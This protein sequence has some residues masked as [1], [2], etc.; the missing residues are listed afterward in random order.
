MSDF[1]SFLQQSSLDLSSSERVHMFVRD[2][3]Y[4]FHQQQA[5]E[6]CSLF[7]STDKASAVKRDG[8]LESL[9]VGKILAGRITAALLQSNKRVVLWRKAGSTSSGSWVADKEASPGNHG[10]L[11]DELGQYL[12][13]SLD[14]SSSVIAAVHANKS[15]GRVG[16]ACANAQLGKLVLFEFADDAD[17]SVLE[18]VLVQQGVREV[19]VAA[20]ATPSE[21]PAKKRAKTS[22]AAPS[23]GPS[24]SPAAWALDYEVPCPI[25][26]SRWPRFMDA[27]FLRIRWT[28]GLTKA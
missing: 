6:M 28:T 17:G 27:R 23:L 20:A 26:R 24:S 14:A 19:L 12:S 9:S 21:G 25:C 10:N 16:V 5:R 8:E 13:K 3:Y 11:L 18:S 7:F 22:S 15:S 1:L 2:G 4:S